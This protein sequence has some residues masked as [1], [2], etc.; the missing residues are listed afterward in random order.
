MENDR[1]HDCQEDGAE[2]R[3]GDEVTEVK[4]GRGQ[5]QQEDGGRCLFPFHCHSSLFCQDH[6]RLWPAV[7]GSLFLFYRRC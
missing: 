1:D 2:K 5:S 7:R 6:L 3:P 4:G